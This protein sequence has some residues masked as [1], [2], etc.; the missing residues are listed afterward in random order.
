MS[1]KNKDKTVHHTLPY[2]PEKFIFI[3]LGG[4]NEI[5][6]NLNLFIHQNQILIVD[7]GISFYDRVGIDVLTPDPSF[8][9]QYKHLIQGI[10][11]THAHEDHVGALPYLWPYLECPLYATP[12]TAQIIQNK[13]YDKL[14]KKRVDI[15]ELE[16][17][18]KFKI[19]VFDL[20]FITLTHSIPEPNAI[21]ISTPKGTVLH[22][23]DWKIDPQPQIGYETNASRLEELGNEGVLALICDSTNI[24][25]DGTSGSEQ[26]VYDNLFKVMSAYPEER[27]IM[28]CFASNVA[29]VQS[30]I[31]IAHEL[32]RKTCLVGRSMHKMVNAARES[33]YLQD[34]PDLISE[35]E[36]KQYKPHQLCILTTGSQGEFKAG[37]AR[38][39]SKNHQQIRITE[40]DVVIFSSRVIPGNEKSISFI[41]NQII[42]QGAQIITSSEEDIHTSG[43]PA[44]EE[45]K[46]MYS[47]VKPR[48]LIPVHGDARH[49]DA[50]GK[51]AYECGVDNIFIPENGSVVSL[52]HDEFDEIEVIPTGKWAY[53]GNR[54]IPLNGQ[55]VK[56]RYKLSDEG[57][58]FVTM[59]VSQRN[60]LSFSP[61]VKLIG[62]VATDE[63]EKNII[64]EIEFTIS[65]ILENVSVN[66]KNIVS[67]IESVIR[68]MIFDELHK[69]PVVSVHLLEE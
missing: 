25:N 3:P 12:F 54:L 28:S 19:G 37:L 13:I 36:I 33:G 40:N 41:Q 56:E 16:L 6:M 32:G 44:K 34:L 63:E 69:K 7:L 48:F 14:W 50:H 27:L 68:K 31:K 4:C 65:R 55:T 23:G 21:K 47:W 5:G 45:L 67:Q 30:I 42:Q 60:E 26:E 24:F 64:Q 8:L 61:V 10:V 59:V 11:F 38:I 52:S 49:L 46:Q 9:I 35:E 15:H 18:S 66:Q 29:R 39:V 43:H 2:D 57:A 58:C 20:E 22:T 51:F 1:K 53:D 17:N 62:I